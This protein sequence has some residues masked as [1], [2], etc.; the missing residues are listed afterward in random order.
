LRNVVAKRPVFRHDLDKVDEDSS[1]HTKFG[2][3]L[4]SGF[5]R[6]TKETPFAVIGKL[7]NRQTME[8]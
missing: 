1:L 8:L 7:G 5:F 2:D 3:I 6:S 4:K